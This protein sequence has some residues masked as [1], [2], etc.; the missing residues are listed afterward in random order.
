M[1]ENNMDKLFKNGLKNPEMPFEEADWIA[2]ER[3][4]DA[5]RAKK[6][7]LIWLVSLSAAAAIILAFFIAIWLPAPFNKP[8][9]DVVKKQ[10]SVKKMIA[11]PTPTLP[12]TK[13]ETTNTESTGHG[14]F[15]EKE[16]IEHLERNTSEQLGKKYG[17]I[18]RDTLL[19]HVQAEEPTL[20]KGSEFNSIPIYEEPVLR[21]AVE[22]PKAKALSRQK[23]RSSYLTI[24][25]APDLTTVQGAGNP[26]V[27]QNIGVLYTMS[28][29][30]KFSVSGGLLYAKKNYHSP[31]SFYR[32]KIQRN[33]GLTP[34]QVDAACDVLDIPIELN[35]Q[36]Y[37]KRATQIKI[38]AGVSSYFMLR[39][40]Y[41][42]SYD[43][44]N[45]DQ[46]NLRTNYEVRGQNNHLLGV[47]NIS[48][49][50]EQELNNNI[51]IGVRPFIKL[52]LTGIGYGQTKLESKGLAVSVSF[53]LGK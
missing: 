45:P 10:D 4:L 6:V 40:Q 16:S 33:Y 26:Q 7:R 37:S 15:V 47:A 53:K 36:L 39:E 35:Y 20:T 31:Y 11:P 22:Q 21:P 13:Q 44:S 46:Q 3:K 42:F 25:A 38:S 29:S 27:S 43:T 49:T 14:L 23:N 32:P 1:E 18:Y 19:A 12:S 51:T 30:N 24:L 34:S 52:P 28:L 2:M 17:L 5:A 48:A 8:V 9:I 50:F 41:K